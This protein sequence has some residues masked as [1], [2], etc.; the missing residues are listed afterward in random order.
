MTV[1]AFAFSVDAGSVSSRGCFYF[2]SL[3]AHK[4]DKQRL[5]TDMQN[6]NENEQDIEDVH[7]DESEASPRPQGNQCG[8]IDKDEGNVVIDTVL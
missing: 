2:D 5:E 7:E 6:E 8:V 3:F 1:T 4:I